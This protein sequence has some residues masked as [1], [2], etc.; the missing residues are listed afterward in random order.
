MTLFGVKR[1]QV[2]LTG[3]RGCFQL[4]LQSKRTTR[5]RRL[6]P[7]RH[8]QRINRLLSSLLHVPIILQQQGNH[9]PCTSEESPQK[10]SGHPVHPLLGRVQPAP[11]IPEDLFSLPVSVSREC[12]SLNPV[13][14]LTASVSTV[15]ATTPIFL[16]QP[17][18]GHSILFC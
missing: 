4:V 6:P 15:Y 7:I 18:K 14:F 13:S 16:R 1:R 2:K 8:S 12:R 5:T 10:P 9:D 17:R 11:E 3:G